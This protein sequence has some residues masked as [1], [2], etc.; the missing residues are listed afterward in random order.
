MCGIGFESSWELYG[1]SEESSGCLYMAVFP[2]CQRVDVK[3]KYVGICVQVDPGVNDV[4]RQRMSAWARDDKGV[5]HGKACRE[6]G[7]ERECH[8]GYMDRNDCFAPP[9]VIPA[10]AEQEETGQAGVS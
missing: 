5:I 8:A 1:V 2:I 9:G 4:Q 6:C 7:R 10:M 3:K